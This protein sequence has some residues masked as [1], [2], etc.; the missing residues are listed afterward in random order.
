MVDNQA[1]MMENF[2]NAMMKLAV[3]GQNT[4]KLIDCSELIPEP[5]SAARKQATCVCITYK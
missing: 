1:L 4:N 5:K 3:V 2:R